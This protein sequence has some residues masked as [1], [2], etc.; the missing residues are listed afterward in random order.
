MA[1]KPSTKL[2][3][4]V[5]DC[6]LDLRQTWASLTEEWLLEEAQRQI[7]GEDARGSPGMF[8]YDY[9]RAAELLE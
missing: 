3:E 9:L 2:R 1:S 5:H 6:Y 4:T 8:L 7:A